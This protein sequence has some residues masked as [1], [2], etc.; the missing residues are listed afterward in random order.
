[1]LCTSGFV[2]DVTFYTMN[3]RGQ[4]RRRRTSDNVTW[5][6]SPDG[7]TGDEVCRLRLHSARVS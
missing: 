5:S 2:D 3:R 4:N 7:G 6:S 1:M